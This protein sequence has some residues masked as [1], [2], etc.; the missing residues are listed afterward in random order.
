M[1]T[2]ST[3]VEGAD[4]PV[5][6]ELKPSTKPRL[7]FVDNLRILLITLVVLHHLAITY[8]HTGGWYYYEG[9]PDELTT[10]LFTIFTAVNQAFFMGFFFMISGY[11][12]PG[13]YDRKGTGPFLKDRLLRL[14]IPMLCY[15]LVIGPLVAYPLIR[16]G[17]WESSG[18]Y[19]EYLTRYYSTFHIGT[20]PL[21]F[22]ESLLIFAVFY[23]LWRRFARP[24]APPAPNEGKMPGNLAVGVPPELRISSCFSSQATATTSSNAARAKKIGQDLRNKGAIKWKHAMHLIRLL[25]SGI[26]ILKEGF[27][28]LK[29]EEYRNQL[30]TIRRGEMSWEEVDS[31]RLALHEKFDDAFASTLLPERPDYEQANAFLVRARRSAL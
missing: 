24:T 28:P 31:W 7:F 17:A 8:G 15:D 2:Q 19:R 20:G 12:T 10:I 25:L 26:V 22:V 29:V 3:H 18:S 11:F 5:S 13:S 14:G 9:Q 4:T 16:T 23:M 30:L 6:T 1:T 21:W 27:V